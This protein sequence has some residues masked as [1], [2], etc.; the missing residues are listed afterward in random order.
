MVQ[1]PSTSHQRVSARARPSIIGFHPLSRRVRTLYR[2]NSAHN[3]F[4]VTERC[5]HL[6]LMCS[7][8]PRNVDD[9]WII[10][11]IASSIPLISAT[12]RSIGLTGGEP[13]LRWERFIPLVARFSEHLPNT[14]LHVLTNGRYFADPRVSG[15]WAAV[16][17]PNLCAAIPIYSSVDAI[18][19]HV[20]Q[21]RGALDETL[22][23]ILRLKDRQQRVEVRIVLHALTT[24]SLVE[25]CRWLARNLP[26]VDHVAL[27]GLEY[28]GFVLANQDVL[29]IDP[30][31]YQTE[32]R[33]ASR[34]FSRDD[35]S[36]RAASDSAVRRNR[37]SERR[38][39]ET[40]QRKITEEGT[41]PTQ[42]FLGVGLVR[43]VLSL[44]ASD[45]YGSRS[46]HRG[47]FGSVADSAR[48]ATKLTRALRSSAGTTLWRQRHIR[49]R[50]FGN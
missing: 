24:P 16:R 1:V 6:C 11:E 7:Q 23:G 48:V 3:S 35:K 15:A 14:R 26:F 4:L 42:T 45:R 34:P 29:W 17:H 32:L 9:S 28:T 13:L 50:A 20:V 44:G 22:L 10:D 18:H 38:R 5:N 19:D 46:G 40:Q 37:L 33:S 27:M 47:C 41:P 39:C 12:T 49:L 2:Q 25:T 21:S 30:A 8:P 36:T 31:D 43:R